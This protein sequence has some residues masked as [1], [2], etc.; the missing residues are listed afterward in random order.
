MLE[1]VYLIQIRTE[2]SYDYLL[3]KV[4][5]LGKEAVT[6]ELLIYLIKI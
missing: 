2:R 5:K 4:N 1:G 6:N 3:L